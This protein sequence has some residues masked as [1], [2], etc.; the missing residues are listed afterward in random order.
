MGI[1][2]RW[3]RTVRARRPAP[4]A[5]PLARLRAA[6]QEQLRLVDQARRAAAD[7]AAQRRRVEVMLERG[8]AERADAHRRAEAAIAAGRE[9]EARR[10][11]RHAVGVESRLRPLAE[12]RRS[13]DRQVRELSDRLGDLAAHVHA[14][15]VRRQELRAQH[16]AAR[17]ALGMEQALR[18]STQAA[19][20]ARD[21][22][23]EARRQTRE[24]EARARGYA[25]LTQM[26]TAPDQVHAAFEELER[27]R[28]VERELRRARERRAL[29]QHRPPNA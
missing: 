27:E 4:E 23:E 25:E 28:A 17:A 6:E 15:Q 26:A 1:A 9:D 8:A 22:A 10:H 2:R 21:A 14:E 13:L 24:M 20:A 19:S 3:R 11:L 29:G 18:A 16:D 5:A 7:L 12:Q